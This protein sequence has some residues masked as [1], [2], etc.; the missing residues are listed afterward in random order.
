MIKSEEIPNLFQLSKE[1]YGGSYNRDILE[2][3]KFYVEMADRI[4]ARRQSANSFYLSVNS[5]LIGGIALLDSEIVGG[6]ILVSIA[7]V[8]LS[9]LWTRNILSYKS[10]NE[11]KFAIINSIEEKLPVQLY[12][13]EW[14]LLEEG[15][16]SKTHRPFYSVERWVPEIFFVLFIISLL[17]S[18][19]SNSIINIFR[20]IISCQIS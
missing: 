19:D 6:K 10:I 1:E 5:A 11:K 17:G 12:S 4:S 14:K 13:M 9:R 2:L 16:S 15:K 3:Y 8:A 18:V 7:G 20:F